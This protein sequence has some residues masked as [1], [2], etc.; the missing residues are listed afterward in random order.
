MSEN[1][2]CIIIL[3]PAALYGATVYGFT[4]FFSLLLAA[5]APGAFVVRR[6]ADAVCLRPLG[7]AE[8]RRVG[9]E[10]ADAEV[11]AVGLEL[12][13]ALHRSH[14]FCRFRVLSAA[15]APQIDVC[16]EAEVGEMSL[17]LEL[18]GRSH[19]ATSCEHAVGHTYPR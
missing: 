19:R 1:V 3:I 9:R 15:H 17:G 18:C 12:R 11:D 5:F 4:M 6:L 14:N 13:L 10:D 16:G 2:V 8:R 7:L